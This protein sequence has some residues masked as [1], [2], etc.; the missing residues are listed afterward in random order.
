MTGSV[1]GVGKTAALRDPDESKLFLWQSHI[2]L[3]VSTVFLFFLN[4][5]PM[6]FM[7]SQPKEL[8]LDSNLI[9]QHGPISWDSSIYHINRKDGRKL[10]SHPTGA[11]LSHVA[12]SYK[13]NYHQLKVLTALGLQHSNLKGTWCTFS[14][15]PSTVPYSRHLQTFNPQD[16][17]R[18]NA[19]DEILV[20]SLTSEFKRNLDWG[21][22]LS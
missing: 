7:W 22:H 14:K 9:I 18:A 12:L 3:L 19:V 15:I 20:L 13:S 8:K 5:L 16:N 2:P 4:S 10:G 11:L 17:F 1:V 21:H 6:S